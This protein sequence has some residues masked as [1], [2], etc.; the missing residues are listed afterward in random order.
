MSRFLVRPFNV[1]LSIAAGLLGGTVAPHIFPATSVHAQ[2]QILAPKTLEAG[3]FQEV[4]PDDPR[5]Q[6]Q[7]P[8]RRQETS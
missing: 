8:E 1:T 4:Q 6:G 3:T 2:A 5:Q 7:A